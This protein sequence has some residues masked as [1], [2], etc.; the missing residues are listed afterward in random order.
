VNETLRALVETMR[1]LGVRRLVGTE[2]LHYYGCPYLREVELSDTIPAPPPFDDELE[3]PEETKP[4]GICIA[5]GCG[6]PSGWRMA[7]AYCRAH[8]LKEAGVGH[9]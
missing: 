3:L 2:S 6:E 4:A 7:P 5:K 1:E 8:G 9:G